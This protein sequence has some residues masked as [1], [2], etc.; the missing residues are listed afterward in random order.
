MTVAQLD[1]FAAN[2]LDLL[3]PPARPIVH[4]LAEA[5]EAT[6][7]RRFGNMPPGVA[8]KWER[9]WTVDVRQAFLDV[10]MAHPGEW[11][12]SSRFYRT[13]AVPR[14][15]GCCW[16]HAMHAMVRAGMLEERPRYYGGKRPGDA[17][18]QGYT[19]EYRWYP[20]MSGEAR[21]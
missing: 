11:I 21:A 5:R 13:V 2:Q 19:H 16:G 10:A 8:A 1:L 15:I 18:Y 7:P 3:A 14:D 9:A 4:A 17:G 6:A 20:P 12:D